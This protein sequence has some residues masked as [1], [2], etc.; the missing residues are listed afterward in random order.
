MTAPAGP[1]E[2]CGGPQWWTIVSGVMYVKCQ[3]GCV[4][5]FPEERYNF[6][7]PDGDLEHVSEVLDRLGFGTSRGEEGV[8]RSGCEANKSARDSNGSGPDGSDLPF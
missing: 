1:C 2:W 8:T 6:S 3:L 5:L 4:S 7:P